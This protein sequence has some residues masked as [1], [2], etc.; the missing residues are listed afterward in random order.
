[1]EGGMKYNC[2][3]QHS[4]SDIINDVQ[5]VISSIRKDLRHKYEIVAIHVIFAA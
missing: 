2:G 4:N 5:D 1:M 3:M